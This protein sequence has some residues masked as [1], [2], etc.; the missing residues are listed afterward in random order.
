MYKVPSYS[1]NKK[2]PCETVCHL[3]D[4]NAS[5]QISQGSVVSQCVL[6]AV[7]HK[8]TSH[9]VLA[10]CDVSLLPSE[11]CFDYFQL[12]QVRPWFLRT[13]TAPR[14]SEQSTP[15][16]RLKVQTAVVF[17]CLMSSCLDSTHYDVVVFFLLPLTSFCVYV[18]V[19]T[20]RW[21]VAS[22]A[23]TLSACSRSLRVLGWWSRSCPMN[24]ASW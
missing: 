18:L 14:P 4:R 9:N 15:D 16:I 13:S 8:L 5:L 2:L 10:M 21:S 24:S 3:S 20:Y 12:W 11:E 19:K 23:R 1:L 22:P 6:C 7:L 17:M